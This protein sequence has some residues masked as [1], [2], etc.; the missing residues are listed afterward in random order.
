MRSLVTADRHMQKGTTIRKKRLRKMKQ[1]MV[2]K[3]G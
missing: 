1:K 3:T 2:G